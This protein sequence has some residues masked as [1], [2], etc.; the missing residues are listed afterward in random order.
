[1]IGSR[2]VLLNAYSE[3]VGRQTGEL[4]TLHAELA[5]LRAEA[6]AVVEGMLAHSCV[7]D[8]GGDMKD[9]SDHDAERHARRFL[10]KLGE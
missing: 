1:M 6:R 4:E 2:D 10:T 7:A 8:A 5:A 3:V 9:V